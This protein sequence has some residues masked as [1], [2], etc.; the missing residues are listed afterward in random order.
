[1]RHHAVGIVLVLGS[2]VACG[3]S[4]PTAPGQGA[5]TVEGRVTNVSGTPSG[6]AEVKIACAQGAISGTDTAE[7]TVGLYSVNLVASANVMNQ[8]ARSV[9]CEISAS[10]AT[11]ARIDTSVVVVFADYGELHPTQD[12]DLHLHN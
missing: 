1:M 8:Y 6:G 11:G 10:D 7:S 5:A 3:K 12:V 2:L 9:P 4:S